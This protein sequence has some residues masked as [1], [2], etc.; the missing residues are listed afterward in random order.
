MDG[1]QSPRTIV[2]PIEEGFL[3]KRRQRS[4][5]LLGGGT[6]LIKFS[7]PTLQIQHQDN[8]KKRMNRRPDACQNGS[9]RKMDDNLVHTTP[10]HH[11]PNMDVF[12][13]TFLQIILAAKWLQCGIQVRPPNSNDDLCFLFC[14]FL[15]TACLSTP[16]V[17]RCPIGWIGSSQ[18][19]FYDPNSRGCLDFQATRPNQLLDRNVVV[20][21]L[22][23]LI[24]LA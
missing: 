20:R 1:N 23:K 5:L 18:R 22:I 3:Q 17:D 24:I 14:L 12:P 2:I 15:L 7:L 11:T 8:F 6:E 21:V 16:P 13:K 4:L 9:F 10:N 19:W